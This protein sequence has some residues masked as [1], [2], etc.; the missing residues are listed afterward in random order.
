MITQSKGLTNL[1]WYYFRDT[2]TEAYYQTK[3]AVSN[4]H[5]NE[6]DLVSY[7]GQQIESAWETILLLIGGGI[8]GVAVAGFFILKRWSKIPADYFRFV[9]CPYGVFEDCKTGGLGET[10]FVKQSMMGTWMVLKR[11]RPSYV[12][13]DRFV[14]AFRQE[15]DILHVLKKNGYRW[16]PRLVEAGGK[17]LGPSH[18]S[19]T[20]AWYVMTRVMGDTLEDIIYSMGH[21]PRLYTL[22]VRLRLIRAVAVAIEELHRLHIAHRDISPGN[23]FIQDLKK[24]PQAILIDFGSASVAGGAEHFRQDRILKEPYA[25]PEQFDGLEN[26]SYPADCYALGILSAEILL[27]VHPFCADGHVPRKDE[28]FTWNR[29]ELVFRLRNKVDVKKDVARYIGEKLLT[30]TPRARGTAEG[31]LAVMRQEYPDL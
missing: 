25:P 19:A 15:C 13:K 3:K 1:M 27:G 16:S 26:A 9:G 24:E 29:R 10:Y 8:A 11:L 5:R 30:V 31:L 2:S 20:D 4:I 22:E 18:A 23:I 7:G 12:V 14:Q 21:H 17:L 28:H 6:Y